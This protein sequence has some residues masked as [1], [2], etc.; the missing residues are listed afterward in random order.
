MSS[1][2]DMN[3][4]RFADI[5]AAYGGNATRWPVEERPGA[6]QLL[7][8]SDVAQGMLAG[9]TTLDQMLDLVPQ[10]AP[11]SDALH[12]RILDIAYKRPAA[13]YANAAA[14]GEGF[15]GRL[16]AVWDASGALRPAGAALA[17]SL[18]LGVVF[19]GMVGPASARPEPVDIVE[20]A[21]LDLTF[22]G[23]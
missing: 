3:M 13:A 23:Y 7:G 15:W 9:E 1:K 5:L 14:S 11:A 8:Q 12:A 4:D 2:N 16:K 21:L 20:L 18:M 17:A 10:P 6:E 19:G 22:T